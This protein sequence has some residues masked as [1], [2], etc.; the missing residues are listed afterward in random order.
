MI[1]SIYRVN[2]DVETRR[3]TPTQSQT[4]ALLHTPSSQQW[5][6][7]IFSIPLFALFSCGF[8]SN[9]KIM[10]IYKVLLVIFLPTVINYIAVDAK[11]I[12]LI[13][14]KMT[15][16]SKNKKI[17]KNK[18]T[19][20][21]ACTEFSFLRKMLRKTRSNLRPSST[22]KLRYGLFV[23]YR[24]QLRNK[25]SY[26]KCLSIFSQRLDLSPKQCYITFIYPLSRSVIVL[27]YQ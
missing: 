4:K 12:Y 20:K 18:Q 5:S 2:I 16:G 26:K 6:M 17:F 24:I 22:F 15:F 27:F 13:L 8:L 9:L 21:R 25:E 10:T 7:A 11:C 3:S 14:K 19:N 1:R 23:F